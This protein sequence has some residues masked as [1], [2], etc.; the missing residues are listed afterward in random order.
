MD[1]QK[2]MSKN[3]ENN[4]ECPLIEQLFSTDNKIVIVSGFLEAIS[5]QKL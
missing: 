5:Y 4:D 2:K 1:T 3:M